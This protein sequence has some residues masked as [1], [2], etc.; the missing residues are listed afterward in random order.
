MH[1]G[2]TRGWIFTVYGSYY[3]FLPT[4]GPFRDCNSIGIHLIIIIIK[5]ICNAHAG[6]QLSTQDGSTAGTFKIHSAIKHLCSELTDSR[7]ALCLPGDV[8]QVEIN[9]PPDIIIRIVCI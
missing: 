7:L 2:G 1:P 4:D 3:I 5:A 9:I 6:V 8:K